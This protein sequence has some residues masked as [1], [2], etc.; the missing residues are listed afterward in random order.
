MHVIQNLCLL[1]CFCPPAV[2]D[3]VTDLSAQSTT[4]TL[5]LTWKAPSCKATG[6]KVTCNPPDCPE[7]EVKIDD[8]QT[9]QAEFKGLS[10]GKEYTVAVVTV[11]GEMMSDGVELKTNTSKFKFVNLFVIS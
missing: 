9:T 8:L 7:S 10:V 6:Y 3:K 1:L 4:D 5:T 2:P 11:N